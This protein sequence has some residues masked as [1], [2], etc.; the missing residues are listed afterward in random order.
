MRAGLMD[1]SLPAGAFK[2]IEGVAFRGTVTY[3]APLGVSVCE[4]G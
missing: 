1:P 2:G 4:R 3:D